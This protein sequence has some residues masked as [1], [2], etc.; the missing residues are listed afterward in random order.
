MKS[1]LAGTSTMSVTL[2]LAACIL[3]AIFAIAIAPGNQRPH[4]SDVPALTGGGRLVDSLMLFPGHAA[5][6]G[7]SLKAFQRT[8]VE[9]DMPP[10]IY[11]P[12]DTPR[13]RAVL[14]EELRDSAGVWLRTLTRSWPHGDVFVESEI[15]DRATLATLRAMFA[16]DGGSEQFTIVGSHLSWRTLRRDTVVSIRE[17]TLV[18]PAFFDG[19]ERLVAEAVL[20]L[21]RNS[22]AVAF[23]VA[24]FTVPEDSIHTAAIPVKWV[25]PMVVPQL[26]TGTFWT[27]TLGDNAELEIWFDPQSRATLGWY[28]REGGEAGCQ[29]MYLRPAPPSGE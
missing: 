10:C 16:W 1:P 8:F 17:A 13:A 15:L 27:V 4:P 9:Y 26:G 18:T 23:Q 6:R 28:D 22:S 20:P 12:T 3:L 5:V 11:W 25:G 14:S 7:A 21:L 29:R 19:T 24:R 2:G